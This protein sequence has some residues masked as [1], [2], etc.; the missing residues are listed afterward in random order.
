MVLCNSQLNLTFGFDGETGFGNIGFNR[1]KF[2]NLLIAVCAS[3][4]TIMPLCSK[5]GK[6]GN[7]GAQREGEIAAHTVFEL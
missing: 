4:S 1:L 7:T 6:P 5:K 2:W 3:A